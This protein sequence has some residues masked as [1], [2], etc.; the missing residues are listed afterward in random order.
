MDVILFQSTLKSA[1]KES[2]RGVSNG[3]LLGTSPSLDMMKKLI[4]DYW[5]GKPED[6]T[7]AEIG[8]DKWSIS[9]KSGLKS[10]FVVIKKGGRYRFEFE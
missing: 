5:Y 7:F 6:Y 8:A 10:G 2:L 3:K 4:A 1:L 9:S